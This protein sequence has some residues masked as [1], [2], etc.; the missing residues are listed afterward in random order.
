MFEGKRGRFTFELVSE[1]TA[2]RKDCCVPIP[3]YRHTHAGKHV[4]S[5]DP[6]VMHFCEER[7]SGCEYICTLP[8]GHMGLHSTT[9][10]NMK[11]RQFASESEE[12]N[13]GSRKY[14]WGESGVAEMCNLH[15]KAR[16]R[17][18]VHLKQ[19]EGAKGGMCAAVS[20]LGGAIHETKEYGPDFD[21]PKDEF[22]HDAYWR[23]M[24][25]KDPC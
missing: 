14:V 9:H 21:I 3:P 24:G 2:V 18:H 10:G 19:C 4:H 13:L 6:C 16:G 11:S 15:C 1:Q 5:L 12:I 25:F 20:V 23:H 22:T 7:C 8:V 17:G